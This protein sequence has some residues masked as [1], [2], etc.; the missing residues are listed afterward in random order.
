MTA[1]AL[2]GAFALA[3]T[4]GMAAAGNA[5]ANLVDARL[6]SPRSIFALSFFSHLAGAIL[7]GTAVASVVLGAI[8]VTDADA[9]TVLAAGTVAAVGLLVVALRVGIPLS[10][11]VVLVGALAG[12]AWAGAGADA[13]V[14][15]GLHGIKPYGVI[16]AALA[17]V[18]GPALGVTAAFAGRR[19]ARRGLRNASQRARAPLDVTLWITSGLVGIADGTND[20]QK[21]MAIVAGALVARGSIEPGEIPMWVR[22][23]VGLVLALGTV[24][25]VRVLR[26]VSRRL[27]RSRSLDAV[28]AETSSA[29]VILA[30]SFVGAPVSTTAVVTSGVVGAGLATRPRHV[31]WGTV[32]RIAIAWAIALPASMAAGALMFALLDAVT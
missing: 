32:A 9:P 15:G 5:S 8:R 20:G 11:G 12:A 17:M 18:V 28:T 14:W 23:T 4:M 3:L 29:A 21:A 2:V 24:L 25:G 6:G 22:V 31:G 13:V 1:I 10:A 27:Y 19:L 7:S 26:T 30:S 16:G